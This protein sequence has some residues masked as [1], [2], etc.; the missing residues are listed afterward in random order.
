M[1]GR[2]HRAVVIGLGRVGSRFDEEAGRRQ[3]WSHVGAYG[4][5]PDRF[6]LVAACETD[7]ANAAAFR[8]RCPGVP[9]YD[10]IAVMLRDSRPDVVSVAT[11]AGHHAEALRLLVS[12]GVRTVWC[13]KPLTAT[14]ADAAAVLLQVEQSRTRL[15]VSYVRRW[16]PLWRRAVELLAQGAIGTPR[17]IRVSVPNRL[18]TMGSHGLDLLSML[19]GPVEEVA[20]AMVPSLREDDEPAVA[21]MLR[22]ASGAVGLLQ[23]TGF[24]RQLVVEADLFGDDGRL[25][26]REDRGEIVAER[27]ADSRQYD[28]YRQLVPALRETAAGFTEMSPFVAIA[29]DIADHLD[30]KEV[31]PRCGAAEAFAVQ[32]LI[33]RVSAAAA[34]VQVA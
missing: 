14:D 21:A 28:G 23:P 12:Q 3:V 1:S 24:R 19:G 15:F 13:E 10:D 26:V 27:F 18:L 2:R 30:G 25:S 7:A 34:A 8:A 16:L 31:P 17:S 6:E 20:A 9:V 33:E 4:A 5:L 29:G 32:A 11:P 22:F